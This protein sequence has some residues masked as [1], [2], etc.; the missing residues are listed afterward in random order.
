MRTRNRM[1]KIFYPKLLRRDIYQD[2]NQ[3]VIVEFLG[4]FSRVKMSL[5]L[6]IK[7]FE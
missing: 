3:D 1:K 6:L 7:L 2:Q 5:S 4:V